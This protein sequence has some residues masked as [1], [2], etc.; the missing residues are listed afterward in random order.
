LSC[1]RSGGLE[2]LLEHK[3]RPGRQPSIPGWAQTALN[4]RL[5]QSEGFN[6]YGRDCQW[7]EGTWLSALLNGKI[8]ATCTHPTRSNATISSPIP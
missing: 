1:Y 8:T 2:A 4:Q 7:L 3:P 6:S 5:H